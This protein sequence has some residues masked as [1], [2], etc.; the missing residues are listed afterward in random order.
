MDDYQVVIANHLIVLDSR[1]GDIIY[2]LL[3]YN[4]LNIM[5]KG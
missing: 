4:S 2:H 3:Y 5:A 1:E